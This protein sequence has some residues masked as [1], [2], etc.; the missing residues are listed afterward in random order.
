MNGYQIK[1]EIMRQIRQRIFLI[2]FLLVGLSCVL[3]AQ[4]QEKI[5]SDK[6]QS[7]LRYSMKHPLHLWTAESTDFTSVILWNTETS[8]ITQV[9]VSCK[10]STFDSKNANRDS[11]MMEVTEA[12]RYPNVTFASTA[13]TVS[14][15]NKLL[16]TG[17]LTFHGVSKDISF[18]AE[19]KRAGKTMEVTGAFSVLMTDYKIE[20]PSLMGIAAEDEI[21]LDFKV[22]FDL[23]KE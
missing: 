20:K 13:I 5:F 18:E 4:K 17:K 11:H 7:F 12:I 6:E 8:A 15:G 14:A 23:K 21:N 3:R 2:F 22:V 19:Q 16:V 10:I 1:S 9:A